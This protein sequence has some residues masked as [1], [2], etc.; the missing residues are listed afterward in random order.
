MTGTLTLTTHV[1]PKTIWIHKYSNAMLFNSKRN[2][3]R[4]WNNKLRNINNPR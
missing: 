2:Y 1:G 4:Y 3:A